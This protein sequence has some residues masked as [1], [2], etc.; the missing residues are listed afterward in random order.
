MGFD[1]EKRGKNL[2]THSLLLP[3][4]EDKVAESSRW[5]QAGSVPGSEEVRQRE[6]SGAYI[7]VKQ[8]VGAAE[9]ACKK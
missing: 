1:Q 8:S 6:S 7:T 2:V 3:Q 5:G 4:S 9:S